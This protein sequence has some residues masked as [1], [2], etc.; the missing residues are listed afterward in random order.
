MLAEF[1]SFG[2]RI[3]GR[4]A[5]RKS[6]AGWARIGNKNPDEVVSLLAGIAASVDSVDFQILLGDERRDQ[7][8][9]TRLRVEFP[10][11]V[12]AFNLLAVEFSAG[13]RHAAMWT[14]ITQR[15]RQAL[16]VASDYE[17]L[18]EQHGFDELSATD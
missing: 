9:L 14:S 7:F 18:F 5:L 4:R 10:A 6:G 2:R 17:G 8:A 15:K 1:R 16:L 3:C 12:R 11:V 13:K